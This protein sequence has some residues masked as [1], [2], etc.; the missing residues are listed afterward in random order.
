[1]PGPV[2]DVPQMRTRVAGIIRITF[3]AL[4]IAAMVATGCRKPAPAPSRHVNGPPRLTRIDEL[5]DAE[6]KYGQSAE[7]SDAVTYQPDVMMLPAG[8][9]AIRAGATDGL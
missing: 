8:A 4:A 5:T 9:A 7:R 2:T 6:K 3:A 1:M